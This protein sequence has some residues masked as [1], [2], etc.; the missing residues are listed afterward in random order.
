MGK[1]TQIMFETFNVP[2]MYVGIQAVLSLYASGRTTGIVLDAGDGVSHT[3]PI[4][5]GYAMPHAI[6]RLDLAGRDVD[7]KLEQLLSQRRGGSDPGL[8]SYARH[9]LTDTIRNLRRTHAYVALN[10][11]KE[12]DTFHD[13]AAVPCALP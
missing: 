2:A 3:V 4:Y 1:M 12:L 5:E 10:F 7:Q 11:R 13:A 6:Q 9:E 8:S